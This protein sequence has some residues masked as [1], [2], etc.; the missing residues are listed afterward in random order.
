MARL[1]KIIFGV[2]VIIT[3]AALFTWQLTG[4]DYY[5]KY[6]VVEQI[7]RPLDPDDPLVAAG[8]YE[9]STTT[10]TVARKDVR[11]G[12]LPTP[13]GVLD[14]HAA[15]VISVALPVWLLGFGLLF[16]NRRVLARSR[17]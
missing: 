9:G 17:S 2:A 7:E 6:E 12:L 1:T 11:F 14:K 3:L 13:S 8:F 4:G 5:T 15:S 10:E 16:W